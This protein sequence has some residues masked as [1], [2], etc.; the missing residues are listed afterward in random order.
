[1]SN[2]PE[3]LIGMTVYKGYPVFDYDK[4]NFMLH[5]DEFKISSFE[6]GVQSHEVL[7]KNVLTSETEVISKNVIYTSKTREPFGINYACYSLSFLEVENALEAY[8]SKVKKS[9]CIG[10]AL[11][12]KSRIESNQ[13]KKDFALSAKR[14]SQF[15]CYDFVGIKCEYSRWEFKDDEYDFFNLY[16]D[17]DENGSLVFEEGLITVNRTFSD[18]DISTLF[19]EVKSSGLRHTFFKFVRG[20][21]LEEE[22]KAQLIIDTFADEVVIEMHRKI[23]F[24]EMFHKYLQEDFSYK[25]VQLNLSI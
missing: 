24:I 14:L 13:F 22:N 10:A 12:L 16:D 4:K 8:W 21:D 1:M 25:Y 3:L 5:I 17:R 9:I 11:A 23:E 20:C 18:S 6:E 15:S 19:S 2:K 7:I